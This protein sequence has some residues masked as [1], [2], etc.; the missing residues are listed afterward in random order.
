MEDPL[1]QNRILDEYRAPRNHG[2]KDDF[3]HQAKAA[4]PVCG[5]SII[6]R[7]KIEN[8]IVEEVSFKN[9]GC[10]I[11]TASA[12]LFLA[13]IKGRAVKDIHAFGP[14]IPLSLLGILLTPGRLKCGTLALEAV[15]E[16]IYDGDTTRERFIDRRGWVPHETLV[17]ELEEK[18]K[19]L[20]GTLPPEDAQKLK[21]LKAVVVES[22]Q[23][24]A[25]GDTDEKKDKSPIIKLR[26]KE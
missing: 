2:L 25:S 12:S 24:N 11:S 19:A 17:N 1:Y 20:G 5:D 9:I 18:K 6:I 10:V 21:E 22:L 26:E 15:R 23:K 13:F 4:N 16:L 14:D 8:G 7:L 3:T